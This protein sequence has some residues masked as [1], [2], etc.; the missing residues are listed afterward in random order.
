MW[1]TLTS[2]VK[3]T[4]NFYFFCGRF[5]SGFQAWGRRIWG[6]HGFRSTPRGHVT[7]SNYWGKKNTKNWFFSKVIL[8]PFLNVLSSNLIV[9]GFHTAMREH[10][11]WSHFGL[12]ITKMWFTSEYSSEWSFDSSDLSSDGLEH[13]RMYCINVVLH[14]EGSTDFHR[15]SGVVE[16]SDTDDWLLMQYAVLL[17]YFQR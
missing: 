9:F 15:Q 8:W 11:I 14:G 16:R 3:R 1:P 12:N 7:S 13:D 2:R 10:V 4:S 5:M 6:L 17:E